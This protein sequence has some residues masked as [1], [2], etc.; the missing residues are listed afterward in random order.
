MDVIKLRILRQ[1][2]YLGLLGR[3]NVI[4]RVLII[5][6]NEDQSPREIERCY[7]TSFEGGGRGYMPRKANGFQKL[8]KERDWILP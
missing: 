4:I 1:G 8:A 7:T 3:P 2:D 6:R 5:E